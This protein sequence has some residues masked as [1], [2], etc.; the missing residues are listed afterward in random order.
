[1][2]PDTT[3]TAASADRT[4]EIVIFIFQLCFVGS[5]LLH[6]AAFLCLGCLFSQLDKQTIC[7][8]LSTRDFF[9]HKTVSDVNLFAAILDYYFLCLR[10]ITALQ[11]F[12]CN[13]FVRCC[14]VLSLFLI[15]VMLHRGG[16]TR[17]YFGIGD[18]LSQNCVVISFVQVRHI[19]AKK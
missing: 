2:K 5:I 3:A 11:W 18:R 4:D 1:M 16:K 9:V 7:Q 12:Y 6:S 10:R 14:V 17:T 19:F 8:F 15:D 13:R